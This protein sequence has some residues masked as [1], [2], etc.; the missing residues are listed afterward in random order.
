VRFEEWMKQYARDN[1]FNVSNVEDMDR[2][3]L[4]NNPS[5]RAKRYIRMKA[6]GN[7]Y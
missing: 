7:H 4:C 3:L 1:I 6:F 5:Q 2:L